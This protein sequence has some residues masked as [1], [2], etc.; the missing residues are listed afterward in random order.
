MDNEATAGHDAE[1]ASARPASAAWSV[2]GWQVRAGYFTYFGAIGAL[3]PFAALYYRELG[4]SG[5]QVGLLTALPSV[6]AALFGPL[7]GAVSDALGIHRWVMRGALVIAAIAAFA[8]AQASAFLPIL[9]L[10]GLLSFAS[11]P[12]APLL[13]SYGVTV[14]E[15][16]GRSYGSLRV[17]GSI[18]YMAAVLIVGRLMG[19]NASSLL[20][21]AH[22]VLV[23]L[24]LVAVFR[25]PPLAQR[26]AAPLFDGLKAVVRNRPT[27]LLLLVAYLLAVGAAFIS[28]YLG[29]RIQDIG[30]SA[31]Q[32]GLAFAVASGSELP[33]IAASGWLLSRLGAPRLVALAIVVYAIRF[34]AF[35]TI[36]VPEWLLP[37]QALHGLSYG[38]FMMASV[39][40]IHRLAGQQ[41]AATAQALLTAVSMGFGSITG[42]L[43]G[44]AL[45]DHIDT[46]G[47]F[48]IAAVLMAITL[49]VL[50]VGDRVVGLDRD[51]GKAAPDRGA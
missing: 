39:T 44:G 41:H 28:I 18:G 17:W 15:H 31:S 13:D 37:V 7:W 40:L 24:A 14:S 46:V 1:S 11:V 42:S 49:A 23:G 38:A 35:S 21:L 4:F 33:V 32:V 3:M 47:L 29:I 25:L 19:D 50:L 20:L 48:R 10:F 12:V 5:L 27:A 36:T 43:I 8:T 45:L 30:G 51:A 6:G 9:L 22:G 16:A 34:I 26:R 2:A